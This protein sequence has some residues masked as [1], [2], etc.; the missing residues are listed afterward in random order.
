MTIQDLE[1]YRGKNYVLH[2]KTQKE[3]DSLI[4]IFRKNCG[5]KFKSEDF[6][7][8]KNIVIYLYSLNNE[9]YGTLENVDLK[10]FTIISLTNQIIEVW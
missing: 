7:S 10:Q 2:V 1:Q 8:Y 9:S 4:H 6:N 5:S 3:W